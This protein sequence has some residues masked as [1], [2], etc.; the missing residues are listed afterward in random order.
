MEIYDFGDTDE[1]I[2]NIRTKSQP[3]PL[4]PC[5]LHLLEQFF[6]RSLSSPHQILCTES[7]VRHRRK[8]LKIAPA[9]Y[10]NWTSEDERLMDSGAMECTKC[11]DFFPHRMKTIII[12]TGGGG[13]VS[14]AITTPIAIDEYKQKPSISKN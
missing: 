12:A 9:I 5:L 3:Q 6:L 1:W 14:L 13:I 11:R 2:D 8:R 10:A 4:Q 7:N